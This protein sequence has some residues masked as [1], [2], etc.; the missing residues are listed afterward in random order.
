MAVGQDDPLEGLNRKIGVVDSRSDWLGELNLPED[1]YVSVR[2]SY[3][4]RREREVADVRRDL[5]PGKR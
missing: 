2:D 4:A 5:A 3:L 1:P